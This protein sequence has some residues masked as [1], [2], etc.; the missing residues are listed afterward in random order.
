MARETVKLALIRRDNR[1]TR[2]FRFSTTQIEAGKTP[3]FV[4][5]KAATYCLIV[6]AA[7]PI[8]EMFVRH[9]LAAGNSFINPKDSFGGFCR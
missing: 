9:S 6:K 5:N 3:D 8:F 7:S 1:R 2:Q 4:G